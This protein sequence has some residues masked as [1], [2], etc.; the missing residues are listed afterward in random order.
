[1]LGHRVNLGVKFLLNL[2]YVLLVIL[3]DEIDGQSD[4]SKPATSANSVQVGAAFVGEV[5]VDN[6]VNCRYID[7]SGNKI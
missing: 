5:E 4:L 3:S 2:D 7:T 1:M 6:H